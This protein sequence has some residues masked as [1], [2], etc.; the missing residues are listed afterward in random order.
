M[1]AHVIGAWWV[2]V[3]TLYLLLRAYTAVAHM[4]ARYA[5]MERP[6]PDQFAVLLRD[7]PKAPPI[8]SSHTLIHD[9]TRPPLK[10][11][12][13]CPTLPRYRRDRFE[14]PTN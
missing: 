4:C 1:W 7:I 8:V 5:E 12:C 13:W 11:R 14:Y 10:K 9:L 3:S 2:S 6:L